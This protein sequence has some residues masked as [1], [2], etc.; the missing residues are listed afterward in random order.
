MINSWEQLGDVLADF[1]NRIRS[2]ENSMPSTKEEPTEL[3]EEATI[4]KI[5]KPMLRR[6]EAKN[7][8]TR[9]GKV[10]F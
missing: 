5:I 7:T 2:L 3:V 10:P 1:E 4:E 9:K 8:V 6:L